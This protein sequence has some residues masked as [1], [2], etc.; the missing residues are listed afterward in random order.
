[1]SAMIYH[2]TATGVEV[3]N[4]SCPEVFGRVAK[5]VAAPV[6]GCLPTIGIADEEPKKDK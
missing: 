1:M 4:H 2:E 3:G 5:P 6:S